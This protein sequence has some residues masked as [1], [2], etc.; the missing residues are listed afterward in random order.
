MPELYCIIII[1]IKTHS[2]GWVLVKASEGRGYING[3]SQLV[4]VDGLYYI[5]LLIYLTMLSQCISPV[6]GAV[7]TGYRWH[8]NHGPLQY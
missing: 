8:F 2:R 5:G 7:K 4:H 3:D 1:V 6:W